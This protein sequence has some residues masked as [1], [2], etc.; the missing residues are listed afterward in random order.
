MLDSFPEKID[1]SAGKATVSSG[2]T[3]T[4]AKNM[5]QFQQPTPLQKQSEPHPPKQKPLKLATFHAQTATFQ[6]IS[7]KN[8]AIPAWF[9]RQHEM[10]RRPLPSPAVMLQAGRQ[11]SVERKPP[12]KGRCGG[13]VP[14]HRGVTG[15]A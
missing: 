3:A 9:S 2:N 11:H 5:H 12:P 4:Q 10:V 7:A 15:K 14:G 1:F 8:R 6:R 13:N